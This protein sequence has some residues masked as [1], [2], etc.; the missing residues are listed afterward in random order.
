MWRERPWLGVGP[1]GVK[2]L[3]EG[4][5][6][7]EAYK[8]R[9]SHVHNAALQILVERGLLGLAAWL[10]IWIA[11]YRDAVAIL[12]RLEP[13]DTTGRAVVTG[14]L[15]AVTGFLIGGLSEHN[16]GDAE[17]VTLAWTIMALPTVVARTP[18]TEG[19]KT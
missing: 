4:Y 13:E 16:F 12:R 6:R 15:A 17:V 10:W 3:Y 1:G 5:A 2:R 14:T 8:K 11:F 9:T 18:P 19:D 7:P